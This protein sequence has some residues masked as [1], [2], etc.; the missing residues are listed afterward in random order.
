MKGYVL[1]YQTRSSIMFMADKQKQQKT[2]WST[3]LEEAYVFSSLNGALS[4]HRIIRSA[5]VTIIPLKTAK[6]VLVK[7][8]SSKPDAWENRVKSILEE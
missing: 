5:R 1:V 8:N 2:F 3:D 7:I 4:M 6:E